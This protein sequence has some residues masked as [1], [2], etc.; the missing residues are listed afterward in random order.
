MAHLSDDKTVAKMGHPVVVVRSDVGHP[1]DL[2]GDK[3]VAK[4]GHPV[5]VVRS[6]SGHPS[7][8]SLLVRMPINLRLE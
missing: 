7:D 4:M 5:V 8:V 2:S 1:P 6:D 3:T